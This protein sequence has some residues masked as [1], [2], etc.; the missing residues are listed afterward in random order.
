M[1]ILETVDGR[2]IDTIPLLSFLLYAKTAGDHLMG[3][4]RRNGQQVPFD[5][6]LQERRTTARGR[7]VDSTRTG[8]ASGSLASSA[9]RSTGPADAERLGLRFTSGIVVA[10]RTQDPHAADVSLA[11]GDVIYAVN[12]GR[13]STVPELQSIL[14]AMPPHESVVLQVEREGVLVFVAFEL[15]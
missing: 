3:T 15:D 6:V 11:A 2:A 5:V 4:V 9:S 7:R 10:A 12:G 13:V 1:D 8:T 14:D